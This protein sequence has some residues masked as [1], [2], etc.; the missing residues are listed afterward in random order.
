TYINGESIYGSERCPFSTSVG[1]FTAKGNK[2]YFHVFPWPG[3]EI[4]IAGV[5]NDIKDAYM[6]A[7]GEPVKFSKKNGRIIFRNLPA[8]P[9]D[10]YDTVIALELDGKPQ[11]FAFRV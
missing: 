1:T 8:R 6:L 4:C 3:R 9:S 11:A 10:P 5:G 7:T 2:A